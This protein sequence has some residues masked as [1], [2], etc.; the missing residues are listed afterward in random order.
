MKKIEPVQTWVNGQVKT[1]EFFELRIIADDLQSSCT[2]YYDLKAKDDEGKPSEQVSNGNVSL[3]GEEYQEWDG[4][5]SWAYTWAAE[6]LNL[7]I[8]EDYVPVVA[9]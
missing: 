3:A 9:E 7:V 1:A 5:N 4:S 6:S 8:V 2:F